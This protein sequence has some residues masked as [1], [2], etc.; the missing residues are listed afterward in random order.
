M[1]GP[2]ESKEILL[3]VDYILFCFVSV[4]FNF[5]YFVLSFF[6]LQRWR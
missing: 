4:S 2:H 5:F 6:S 3:D 1:C